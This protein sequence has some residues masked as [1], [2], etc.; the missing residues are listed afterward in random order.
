MMRKSVL[1]LA[2]LVF[3]ASCKLSLNMVYI[4]L[5]IVMTSAF[6]AEQTSFRSALAEAKQQSLSAPVTSD[7]KILRADPGATPIRDVTMR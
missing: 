4:S 1:L 7:A 3:L 6:A 2:A 5:T